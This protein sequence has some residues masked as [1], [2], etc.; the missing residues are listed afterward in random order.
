MVTMTSAPAARAKTA[1]SAASLS[2]AM[3]RSLHLGSL[4]LGHGL[5]RIGVG[6]DD[7]VGARHFAGQD[8]FVAGGDQRD[9]GPAV[10]SDPRHIHRRRSA[11]D[12]RAQA[13]RRQRG[14][15]REILAA[16]ADIVARLR[17]RTQGDAVALRASHPPAGSPG[18]APRAP[19]RR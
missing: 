8:Q 5:Q 9:H 18:L 1:R 4:G 14:A 12:R 15:G 17:R 7:L 6:G 10:A 3:G 2:R 11:P 13:A 16:A 19:A